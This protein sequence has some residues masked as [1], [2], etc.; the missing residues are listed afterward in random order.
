MNEPTQAD[1]DLYHE[2]KK[3]V[4]LTHDGRPALDGEAIY[5]IANHRPPY[6]GCEP[7]CRA[8]ECA[9]EMREVYE[10]NKPLRWWQRRKPYHDNGLA[11]NLMLR[12][13][14]VACKHYPPF[15]STP[16]HMD[17]ITPKGI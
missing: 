6:F 16:S 3:K 14:N 11:D 7:T 8:D 5:T 15:R 9:L 4:F 1:R 12:L 10:A 17:P 13:L 2:L